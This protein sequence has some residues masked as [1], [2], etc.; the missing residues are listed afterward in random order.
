MF[1]VAKDGSDLGI[2]IETVTAVVNTDPVVERAIMHYLDPTS[3][4]KKLVKR[5]IQF[6]GPNAAV[7]RDFLSRLINLAYSSSETSAETHQ[8]G[9]DTVSACWHIIESPQDFVEQSV[10]LAERLNKVMEGKRNISKGDMLIVLARDPSG[11]MV[12]ILKLEQ[13]R[14]FERRYIKLPDGSFEV[15][16]LLNEDVVSSNH[17][18]QKS[19]FVR[20]RM[21]SYG[22]GYQI[23]LHDKQIHDKD[24]AAKFF[25]RDFL[26][27]NLLRTPAKR[28]IDFCTGAEAWRQQ[29]AQ[30]LPMHGILSFARALEFHLLQYA[31]VSFEAFAE[32]ALE[33]VARQ[34][35]STS[36]LAQQVAAYV[37]PKEVRERQDIPRTF[38][39]DRDTAE[40]LLKT[41]DLSL[42]DDLRLAG[43]RDS[44]MKVL[45]RMKGAEGDGDRQISLLVRT[46]SVERT[47]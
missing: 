29:H 3:V 9:S 35:L 38:A 17:I 2:A 15:E 43:P 46:G 5:D 19:A 20:G 37:Y 21:H 40:R 45:E 8:D 39:V 25:Y 14:E 34:E 18:P 6:T 16:L 32:H 36:G 41:I 27:C 30:Y 7:V 28:T 13:L 4:E 44:M 33:G 42:S 24:G 47:F 26:R 23:Q 31:E 11:P 1:R 10:Y 12:A 22:R